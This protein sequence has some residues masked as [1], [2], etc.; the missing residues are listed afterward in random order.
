MN[1]HSRRKAVSSV[2][3]R[4][5]RASPP[6]SEIGE[7]GVN[8]V[9]AVSM[10]ACKAGAAQMEVP[11]Y[12][13]VADL[14]GRTA[15][16]CLSLI[17]LLSLWVVIYVGK[18]L[19]GLR[20]HCKWDLETYH[21]LKVVIVEKYGAHG[22]NVVKM[23]VFLPTSPGKLGSWKRGYQQNR[24]YEWI[25]IALDVAATDFCMGTKY[26]LDYKSPNKSGKN[27]KSAEYPI[28]SIEDPFDKEDW[29]HIKCFSSL[30]ICQVVGDDLFVK[31]T[32]FEESN[33]GIYV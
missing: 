8:V 11:L 21:H 9:V 4:V 29:L 30:A 12:K 24:L 22:C 23:V 20:G 18:E 5:F 10:A 25:N 17:S 13:H 6:S 1:N 31:F 14:I 28:V 27:F 7:L 32:T 16:P 26:D 15:R 33:R 19:A 2:I 3:T